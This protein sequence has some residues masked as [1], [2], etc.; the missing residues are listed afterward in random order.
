MVRKMDEIVNENYYLP[1]QNLTNLTFSP[2]FFRKVLL[3]LGRGPLPKNFR[4]PDK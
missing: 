3:V 2:G 1:I 4:H